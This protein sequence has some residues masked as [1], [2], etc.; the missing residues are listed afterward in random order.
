MSRMIIIIIEKDDKSGDW[1]VVGTD[2][3]LTTWKVS[4]SFNNK[5]I[6][7]ILYIIYK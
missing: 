1:L 7:V 3:L 4:F 2:G 5:L 6:I